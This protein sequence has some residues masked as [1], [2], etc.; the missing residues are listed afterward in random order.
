MML[1]VAWRAPDGAVTGLS[2]SSAERSPLRRVL[3][4]SATVCCR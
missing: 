4:F 1:K 2:A 3:T